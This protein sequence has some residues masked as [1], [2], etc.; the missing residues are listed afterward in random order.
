[1]PHGCVFNP[2]WME[3]DQ[4]KSWVRP[5]PSSANQTLCR[6]C[7]KNKKTLTSHRWGFKHYGLTPCTSIHYFLM[8]K[9]IHGYNRYTNDYSRFTDSML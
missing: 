6:L 7:K 8:E 5:V 2:K 1:M 3:M 4:F 9:N